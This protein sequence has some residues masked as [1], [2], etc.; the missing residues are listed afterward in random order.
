MVCRGHFTYSGRFLRENGERERLFWPIGESLTLILAT[1][2]EGIFNVSGSN[3]RMRELQGVFE[4][5][6]RVRVTVP[7]YN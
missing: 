1:E 4:T 2:V 6:P 5:P 3:R 7:H